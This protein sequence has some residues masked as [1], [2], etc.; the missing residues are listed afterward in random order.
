MIS[1][2]EEPLYLKKYGLSRNSVLERNSIIYYE[3]DEELMDLKVFRLMLQPFRKQYTSWSALYKEG[4]GYIK[5][6]ILRR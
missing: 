3:V 5:V 1:L 2:R 6:Q 4:R